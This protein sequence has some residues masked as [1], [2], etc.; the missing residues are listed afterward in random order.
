M[1]ITV[2]DGLKY[3]GFTHA[4]SLVQ[5]HAQHTLYTVK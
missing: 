1:V 5:S 3:N 2:I 4:Q